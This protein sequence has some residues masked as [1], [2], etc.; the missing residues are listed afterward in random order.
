MGRFYIFKAISQEIKK[1][2]FILWICVSLI[3]TVPFGFLFLSTLS[4]VENTLLILGTKGIL[5]IA[6]SFVFVQPMFLGAGIFFST[7]DDHHSF[8]KTLNDKRYF[9][10]FFLQYIVYFVFIIVYM[11]G[12]SCSILLITAVFAGDN[13]AIILMM[14]PGVSIAATI[15]TFFLSS[16]AAFLAMLFDDWRLNSFIGAIFYFALAH[17][18]GYPIYSLTY[19]EIALLGPV[20]FFIGLAVIL[21]GISFDSPSD[22][23]HH[24]GMYFTLDALIIPTII[25]TFVFVSAFVGAVKVFSYNRERWS[26]ERFEESATGKALFEM[27][28]EQVSKLVSL[29]HGLKIRRIGTGVILIIIIMIIPMQVTTYTQERTREY[30]T[31]IYVSPSQG[32]SVQIGDWFYK[33]FVAQGPPDFSKWLHCYCFVHILDWGNISELRVEFYLLSVTLEEFQTLND[34]E[35][36]QRSENDNELLTHS[37]DTEG[38]VFRLSYGINYVLSLRFLDPDGDEIVGSLTTI[39]AIEIDVG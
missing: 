3:S 33:S 24:F 34:T 25:F 31:S 6:F 2:H 14:I 16:V 7:K 1:S 23:A 20:Y 30:Y 28:P 12:L 8:V 26:L 37:D 27:T 15:A 9:R 19:R 22:M 35:I 39:I 10:R 11:I 5:Y 32:E 29:K 4:V 21:S 13:A 18:T 17:A 36:V 38:T